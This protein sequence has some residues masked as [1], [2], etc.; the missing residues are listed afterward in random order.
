M[1]STQSYRA[2]LARYP[3]DPRGKSKKRQNTLLAVTLLALLAA[4]VFLG[5]MSLAFATLYVKWVRIKSYFQFPFLAFL[6][7][8]PAV[9]LTFFL[10]FLTSRAWL[11]YALSALIVMGGTFANFFKVVLRN[12]CA[13][14]EDLL[15]LGAAATVVGEYDISLSMPFYIAILLC[16]VITALLFALCR[17]RLPQWR[18]RLGGAVLAAALALGAFQLWYRDDGL[19]KS[20]SNDEWFNQWQPTEYYASRGFLYPFFH[21][22]DDAF[23]PPPAGYTKAKAKAIEAEYPDRDLETKVNFVAVMLESFTELDLDYVEDPYGPWKAL[24]AESLSGTLL[25][26][27]TGGGTINAERSFLTGFAY[28]QPAYGHATESFVWYFR[29]QGYVTE[30]CHPGHNWF[31]NRQNINRCL[32]FENYC[33]S[34]DFFAD[35]T[36]QA[37]AG[38][39]VFFAAVRERYEAAEGP[40][41]SFSVSYQGHSPYAAD[42]L[43]WGTEYVARDG[44]S[45][46]NYYTVNNY[47]GGLA[48]TTAQMARFVDSFREDR[49]PVVLVFFGDHRPTLGASNSA[50]GELGIVQDRATLAGFSGFYATPYLIWANDAAKEALGRDITGEGPTISPCYLMAEVFTACGLEGPG[51]LRLL[52]ETM[53]TVPVRHSTGFYLTDGGLT[54]NLSEIQEK[55][56]EKT[57]YMEYHLRSSK[58]E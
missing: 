48:D 47:L 16:L 21:S 41:F 49:K 39:D 10:Y 20:F 7:I 37:Y 19:Y 18:W 29:D 3:L 6:N 35:R 33:F 46:G 25:S 51:Y 52:Q 58:R 50:Y 2:F 22:F 57:A 13:V 17:G 23:P 24:K 31:Y 9:L 5:C 56:L 11:A 36:D 44:L 14:F 28:P 8:L 12:E 30:G 15:N 40:Y 1:I 27:T 42:S 54:E 43:V 32:G 34:E 4:A 26:D 38:D 53:E 45:E 55:A